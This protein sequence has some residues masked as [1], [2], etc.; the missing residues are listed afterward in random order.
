MG[1]TAEI[2]AEMAKQRISVKDLSEA[3]NMPRTTLSTRLNDHSPFGLDELE[4]VSEVLGVESWELLRR[5][6]KEKTAA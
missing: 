1:I 4:K 3:I 5:A 6:T 2:R